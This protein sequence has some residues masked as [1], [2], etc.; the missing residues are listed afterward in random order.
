LSSRAG[1]TPE[2]RGRRFSEMTKPRCLRYGSG[3]FPSYLDH[4]KFW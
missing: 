4:S 2:F 3:L 1:R